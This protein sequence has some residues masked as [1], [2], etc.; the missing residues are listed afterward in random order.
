KRRGTYKRKALKE[1]ARNLVLGHIKNIPEEIAFQTSGLIPF[2]IP[3]TSRTEKGRQHRVLYDK[4]GGKFQ[5]WEQLPNVLDWELT[6]VIRI[7][8]LTHLGEK[9]SS[10]S[11]HDYK[12]L[13]FVKKEGLWLL[14][15]LGHR[16]LRRE[17]F[18][19]GCL[20]MKLICSRKAIDCFTIF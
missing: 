18:S 5:S 14:L 4:D 19:G 12:K 1:M 15:S 9:D 11:K 8:K 7:K 3:D 2:L 20:R 10:E 17:V 13:T 6:K 16:V